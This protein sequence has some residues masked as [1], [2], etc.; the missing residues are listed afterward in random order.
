MRFGRRAASDELMIRYKEA[1]TQ[2]KFA[3]VVSSK[4]GKRAT[5]RNRMRRVLS[6]SIRHNLDRIR[7]LTAVFVVR[8]NI[9]TRPP[10]DIEQMVTGLLRRTGFYEESRP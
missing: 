5:Q 1:D 10:G 9:A 7:G 4:I 8:Q 2:P 6:E 3:I